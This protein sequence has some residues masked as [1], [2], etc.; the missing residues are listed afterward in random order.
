MEQ[1]E[2]YQ[3]KANLKVG[4]L[5]YSCNWWTH[6]FMGVDR[7][8]PLC[9]IIEAING[10]HVAYRQVVGHISINEIWLILINKFEYRFTFKEYQEAWDEWEIKNKDKEEDG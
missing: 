10:D 5:V 8:H 4:Q 2:S 7:D 3:Y 6:E 9:C 1:P